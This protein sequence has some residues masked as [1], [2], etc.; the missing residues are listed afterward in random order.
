[1]FPELPEGVVPLGFPIRVRPRDSIRTALFQQEIYP[2]V[3][4]PLEACVPA[5][6]E[7]SHHLADE[8]MTLPCDQRYDADDMRRIAAAL[9]EAY[10]LIARSS[11]E[12]P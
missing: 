7:A 5:S 2:P 6:F 8:I 9:R 4:W 12:M 1:M 3:H 11:A 10:G